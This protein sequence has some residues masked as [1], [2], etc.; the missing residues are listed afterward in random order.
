MNLKKK[1]HYEY[2]FWCRCIVRFKN[3][4][5]VKEFTIIL[6]YHKPHLN[7]YDMR[8]LEDDIKDRLLEDDPDVEKVFMKDFKLIRKKRIG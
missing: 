1:H 7:I 8:Q 6:A 5:E 4:G 2:V 3:S